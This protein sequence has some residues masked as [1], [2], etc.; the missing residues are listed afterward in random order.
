MKRLSRLPQIQGE[1]HEA[2][3]GYCDCAS[4]PKMRQDRQARR[5]SN[6]ATPLIPSFHPICLPLLNLHVT[7][8]LELLLFF[9][10]LNCCTIRSVQFRFKNQSDYYD[11]DGISGFSKETYLEFLE[12]FF[13]LAHLNAK[14]STRMAFINA[15]WPPARKAYASESATS[16]APLPEMK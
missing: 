9:H 3:V 7:Y 12:N 16:R 2:I 1:A 5:V 11:P 10:I 6:C 13:A 8:L 4:T 14:K 15:D